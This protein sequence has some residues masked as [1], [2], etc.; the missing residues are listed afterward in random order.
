MNPGT[1]VSSAPE[2]EAT[3]LAE[4]LDISGH[5]R[6]D[7]SNSAQTDSLLEPSPSLFAA[8]SALHILTNTTI[9]P[10]DAQSHDLKDGDPTPRGST[11]PWNFGTSGLTPSM[12]DPNSQTFNMF[13][14]QMPGYYTPTPGG[15]NTLYHHQAGDLHTPG[16]G[17]G[18]GTPLS[19]PT[20]ES[21]LNAGHQA[22][23][24]HGFHP[25]L[26]QHVHQQPFQNVNPFQMHQQPGFPPH[27]FTHQPAYEHLDG[28]IEESP[29]DDMNLDI[30]LHQ[31][32]SPHMLFHS[33]TLQH[34]MQPPRP[35]HPSGEK[36]V[37][38]IRVAI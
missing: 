38:I 3:T 2:Q 4:A 21:A 22:A 14:N 35:I 11:E 25:Q 7:N 37:L 36:Y 23:A 19:L 12:M 30:N 24:F 1:G 5:Q 6:Y 34:T 17:M 31:E 32:H 9:R 33:H 16:F 10:L 27:Q 15:T 26:P 20:S 28:P 13:A 18:L 8:A 29:V